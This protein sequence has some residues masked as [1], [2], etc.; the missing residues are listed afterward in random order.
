MASGSRSRELLLRH[1]TPAALLINE[2]GD[3]LYVHGKADHLA[4]ATGA[5][6]NLFAMV[7]EGLRAT[8]ARVIHDALEQQR[9]QVVRDVFVE[10]NKSNQRPVTVRVRPLSQ[11]ADYGAPLLVIFEPV[12]DGPSVPVISTSVRQ[13]STQADEL[14]KELVQSGEQLASTMKEMETSREELGAANEELQ[15]MNE[16]LQSTNE[17]LTTSK[18]EMQS[19]NE[20]LVTINAELQD[21]VD[22]LSRSNSDMKN[23]LH[24]TEIATIF[25]DNALKVKRFTPPAVKVINLIPTDIG[26][27]LTDLAINLK[28]DRLSEDLLD[29]VENL[30]TKEIQVETKTGEW[31][32]MRALPYRTM[33]NVIDGAVLTFTNITRIKS[34][35]LA[36]SEVDL[37]RNVLE[38]MPVMLAA[39]DDRLAVTVW[40]GEC[41]RV[42]Q[43]S[44]KDM[45]GRTDAFVEL[46]PDPTYR[47]KLLQK[48]RRSAGHIRNWEI[49]ITCKDGTERTVALSN[50]SES[51]LVP[52]WRDWGI[53][54]DVTD[55][56]TP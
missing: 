41:E 27:P 23:L 11:V 46:I 28:Y 16:E 35:E 31:F 7:R 50:V 15:S 4:L 5:S 26:R 40:N 18:E 55:P 39:L 38:R 1:F 36:L 45:L 10:K 56:Q 17:E 25:L 29:V 8:L 54:V 49:R 47:E 53:A 33:D 19:M 44:A 9:E 24:S 12:Q 14:K 22:E 37:I 6:L 2:Q 3:I 32:L 20:E 13:T 30:S 43:Y 34:L 52:G 48:H 51:V 42:T 21:K